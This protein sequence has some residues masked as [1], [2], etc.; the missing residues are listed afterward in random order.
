MK[1]VELIVLDADGVL[2]DGKLYIGPNGEEFKSFH[3]K[4]GMGLSLARHFG[5]KTAIIT[6]RRSEAVRVRKEELRIDYL[7]EGISN[8]REVLA[9]LSAD[10]KIPFEHIFYMG[11]DV[12]DLPAIELAGFSA[13]P[14]DAV[15]A[16]KKAVYYISPFPG[17]SG[18]VRDAIDLI[19]SQRE[20]YLEKMEQF[21]NAQY[22]Q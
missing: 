22:V 7:F 12:N 2:T 3:V 4:D 1:K 18:A 20:D 5:I 16:V 17:G 15:I 8:K 19:L 9:S 10:L 11:D 21:F 6:G 13:A 14:S